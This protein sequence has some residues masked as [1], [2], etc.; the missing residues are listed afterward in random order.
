M[1]TLGSR[2][3]PLEA[4]G[5]LIPHGGGP[6]IPVVQD[7]KVGGG[8]QA[9]LLRGA[10]NNAAHALRSCDSGSATEPLM[11]AKALAVLDHSGV[12]SRGF[13][14]QMEREIAQPSAAPL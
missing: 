6:N 1:S 2:V 3:G 7:F 11:S 8:M 5:L 10:V 4:D 9:L 14:E 13:E 12:F